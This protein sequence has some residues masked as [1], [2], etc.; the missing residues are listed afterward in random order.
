MAVRL[1]SRPRCSR[2][3]V[4]QES[5]SSGPVGAPGP[6]AAS[7]RARGGSPRT[8]SRAS[9][10]RIRSRV[11]AARPWGSSGR[12]PAGTWQ[13]MQRPLRS[14]PAWG[15]PPAV[16]PAAAAVESPAAPPAIPA[17]AAPAA[18]SASSWQAAHSSMPAWAR[19]TSPGWR[20]DR[21]VSSNQ[22]PAKT[23][24]TRPRVSA[25]APR[26]VSPRFARTV[27]SG[28]QVSMGQ[29]QVPSGRGPC[30]QEPPRR[31]GRVHCQRSSFFTGEHS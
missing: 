8:L 11:S 20:T 30:S 1:A 6:R 3:Q 31:G 7:R 21:R 27:S 5:P 26:V 19:E 17:A 25:A 9:S 23:A 10:P 4:A 28:W 29:A 13:V 14:I 18:G 15:S 12:S 22:G 2:W 24:S 16:S